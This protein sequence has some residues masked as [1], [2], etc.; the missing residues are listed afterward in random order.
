MELEISRQGTIC[1]PIPPHST[2]KNSSLFT[3][4]CTGVIGMPDATVELDGTISQTADAQGIS[5]D[6]SPARPAL[7]ARYG[8]IG[9]SA[10]AAA[11]RYQGLAKNLAYAPASNDWRIHYAEELA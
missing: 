2:P 1:R 8:Q 3:G 6:S 11:V 5:G 4:Q 9:I 7:D 10:V